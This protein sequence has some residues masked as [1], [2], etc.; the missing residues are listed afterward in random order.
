MRDGIGLGGPAD[1]A[2]LERAYLS[3]DRDSPW[4]YLNMIATIDGAT[5]IDGGSSSIGDEQDLIVFRVL[6]SVADLVL[7]AAST[8][9]AEQYKKPKLPDHLVKL[10]VDRGQPAIPRVAIVTSSL[11]FDIEPFGDAPPIVVTSEN[12]PSKRRA[13]LQ[14]TTDVLICG[15]HQVDLTSA[16]AQ[17]RTTGFGRILSE[18]GPTL[19]GQ[20]AHADLVDEICVTT[21]SMVVSGDSKR[22]MSGH[23]P[24]PGGHDFRLDRAIVGTKSLFTRW[25]RQ[26][27]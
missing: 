17:L 24:I 9:R 19:N 15:D 3:D 10:R 8:V 12:S 4:L 26:R 20:L 21:A 25:L 27:S 5:A 14:Q 7:V 16:L 6:R 23:E 18:G 22:I 2:E 11:D 13:E 1:N